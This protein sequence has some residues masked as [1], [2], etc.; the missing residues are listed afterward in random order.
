MVY[1]FNNDVLM[2]KGVLMKNDNL[3]F[4]HFLA[5][6]TKTTCVENLERS[7]TESNSSGESSDT[8]MML[9]RSKGM[10]LKNSNEK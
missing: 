4:V 6:K 9:S 1:G 2:K 3:T 10:F 8:E 5:N 7:I